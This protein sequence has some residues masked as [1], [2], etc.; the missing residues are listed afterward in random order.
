[1]IHVV[2]VFANFMIYLTGLRN[3]TIFWHWHQ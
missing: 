1:M 3:E 2:I